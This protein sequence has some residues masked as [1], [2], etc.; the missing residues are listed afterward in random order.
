VPCTGKANCSAVLREFM[1]DPQHGSLRT[2][3]LRAL[4]RGT[5]EGTTVESAMPTE[6]TSGKTA[7]RRDIGER[8]LREMPELRR[9]RLPIYEP[10]TGTGASTPTPP[11]VNTPVSPTPGP[12]LPAGETQAVMAARPGGRVPVSLPKALD[13]GVRD[14]VKGMVSPTNLALV[15]LDMIN[16][17][18]MAKEESERAMKVISAR[19]NS[20]DLQRDISEL[21]EKQRLDIARRQ[22]RG[23]NVYVTISLTLSFTKEVLNQLSLSR[24]EVSTADESSITSSVMSHDPILGAEHSMWWVRVSLP[25]GVVEVARS[26]AIKFRLEELEELGNM[27]VSV[28]PETTARLSDERNRLLAEQ[29]RAL[30]EEERAKAEEV[31]KPRVLTDPG[32]RAEQQ[33]ELVERANQRAAQHPAPAP[34]PSSP[35]PLPLTFEPPTPP[36]QFLPYAPASATLDP[37]QVANI[38]DR[39][40][41]RLV[42]LGAGLVDRGPDAPPLDAGKARR[43]LD[44]ERAWRENMKIMMNKYT[45]QD[46]SEAVRMLRDLL[47]DPAKPGPKMDRMRAQ[48]E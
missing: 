11:A 42:S 46:R 8:G 15:A 39:E 45:D 21:I 29:P 20:P 16:R 10:G 35:G 5:P 47:L 32:K 43:F 28:D 23:E 37:S 27:P 7:L 44:E 4:R 17:S 22:H 40:G 25:V 26:E 30:Q 6:L 14:M 24:L 36:M 34:A 12:S 48:L 9:V 38:F 3:S 2:Y 19:V 13:Q 41:Q 1:A 18:S 31:R 33:R